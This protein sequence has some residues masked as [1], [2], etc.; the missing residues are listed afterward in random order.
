M[1]TIPPG[2]PPWHSAGG[3][4]LP[5]GRHLP[6][7][8]PAHPQ[9]RR[10]NAS[11]GA[12]INFPPKTNMTFASQPPMGSYLCPRFPALAALPTSWTAPP[13]TVNKRPPCLLREISLGWRRGEAGRLVGRKQKCWSWVGKKLFSWYFARRW[14]PF[15]V[16]CP[17][18]AW[19]RLGSQKRL[20]CCCTQGR[21]NQGQIYNNFTFSCFPDVQHTHHNLGRR[22]N[23]PDVHKQY[24]P[25][26]LHPPA[27]QVEFF[28]HTNTFHLYKALH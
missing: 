12:G 8:W 10:S 18:N 4:P 23:P 20:C 28:C 19:R 25:G 22:A 2:L 7:N 17:G 6:Y 11:A 5:C 9:Y 15:Y 16:I 21:Y 13:Q 26:V 24:Q 1:V 3:L 27:H 14:F